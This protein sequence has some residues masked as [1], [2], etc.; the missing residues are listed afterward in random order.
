MHQLIQCAV[1]FYFQILEAFE[2]HL[3]SSILELAITLK[4]INI[5]VKQKD[6]ALIM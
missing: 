3:H 2:T 6:T 4:A 1:V 5:L